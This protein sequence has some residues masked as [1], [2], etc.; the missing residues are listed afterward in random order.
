MRR[1]GGHRNLRRKLGGRRP[2][3]KF[4]LI[5]EGKN[6]EPEYFNGLQRSQKSNIVELKIFPDEGSPSALLRY[7]KKLFSGRRRRFSFEKDDQIWILFDKD[8]HAC[9]EET[10]KKCNESNIQA[11]F[12]NPCFE[13]WLVLHFQDHNS[14]DDGAAIQ[15]KLASLA[16][17]YD[18]RSGKH[19]DFSEFS[20]TVQDAVKRATKNQE[21]RE[22]E[23]D[24]YGRPSTSI[25]LLAT[26][27]LNSK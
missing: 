25:H 1:R 9:F 19:C 20:E 11:G 10:I 24:A 14:L 5:C 21:L 23:N 17:C 27:L 16:K 2:K 13:Y 3:R 15:K 4:Y 12:S 26:E 7:A 22:G 8:E 6:T 18:P